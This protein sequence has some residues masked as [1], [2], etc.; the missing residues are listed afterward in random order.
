[1]N[2]QFSCPKC[3]EILSVSTNKLICNK[4]KKTFSNEEGY[5]DFLGET[6]FETIEIS[7]NK[8]KEMLEYIHKY[9]YEKAA[10]QF[11]KNSEIKLQLQDVKSADAIF[12]CLGKNNLRCLEIGSNLGKI[13]E[14]LSQIFH[15]V[16]SLETSKEKIEIQKNKFQYL[17]LKNII[18]VR[19]NPTELPFVENYFD[20]VICNE[21]F[22]LCELYSSSHDSKNAQINFLNE[23]KRTLTHEGCL[24]LSVK[25]KF[26]FQRLFRKE[27]ENFSKNNLKP[28]ILSFFGYQQLFKKI[29]FDFK[30]YWVLP[31]IKKP[32]FSGKIDD[33]VSYQW[34]FQNITDFLLKNQKSRIKN[35]Y[36][37]IIYKLS[38][39]IRIK[40]FVPNYIFCCYKNKISESLEDFIIRSTKTKNFLTI[41]R[42]HRILYIILGKNKKPGKLVSINRYGL[43]IPEKIVKCKRIFPK[44]KDPIERL[45]EDD[46][47]EGKPIDPANTDQI[48]AAFNW[49]HEFQNYTS[50]G[51][52]TKK[53]IEETE[54]HWIRNS[55]KKIKNLPLEQYEIWLN[56]YLSYVDQH[57][58]YKTGV[59]GDFWYGNIL[60]ESKTQ[61]VKV[62]DWENFKEIGNPFYD[63]ML[64]I[65]NFM[66]MFSEND[67]ESFKSNFTDKEKFEILKKLQKNISEQFGFECKLILLLRWSI[68]WRMAN[69]QLNRNGKGIKG[70][71]QMLEFISD[72]EEL[73]Y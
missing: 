60:I 29:N 73:Y 13:S 33:D 62:I 45:W 24:C 36:F 22:E 4:C 69:S 6:D 25:N 42:K 54:M 32:Y 65:F 37:L 34:F 58:I 19:G 56:K 52:M 72:K 38:K 51:R 68:L 64:F 40:N 16:Y 9:G 44:M 41:S 7:K 14:N 5:I 3:K 49:L 10:L 26:G 17:N 21:S 28:V 53:F 66:I 57:S 30:S 59:H 15:Q 47:I 67:L 63:Y 55:L 18:L 46:W 43:I 1:M 12:H 31:S 8:L 70:Y 35:L 71:M 39:F 48:F 27:K 61:N 50:N 11:S 2:T 20:L 23:I